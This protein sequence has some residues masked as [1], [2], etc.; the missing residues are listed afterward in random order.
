MSGHDAN[1]ALVRH[2]EVGAPSLRRRTIRLLGC[3]L[4]SLG[5][6][7]SELLALLDYLFGRLSALLLVDRDGYFILTAVVTKYADGE[8]DEG[9]DCNQ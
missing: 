6:F 4:A 2:A 7:R 1:L 5:D 3:S 9:D 8:Q